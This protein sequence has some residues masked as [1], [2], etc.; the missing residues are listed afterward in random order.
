M[1]IFNMDYING[2][3]FSRSERG[4]RLYYHQKPQIFRKMEGSITYT[5]FCI[6]G[7]GKTQPGM[8]AK[9]AGQAQ[10]CSLGLQFGN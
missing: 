10:R 6:E 4:R 8:L 7:W 5:K 9:R 1:V 2:N 3:L